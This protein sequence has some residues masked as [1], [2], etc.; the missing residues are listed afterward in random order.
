M[1]FT[2][3]H[4]TERVWQL[5]ETICQIPH[6]SGF[7]KQ[8]GDW[9][10]RQAKANGLKVRRDEVG[11]IRIDRPASPGFGNAPLTILQA[12]LDMVPQSEE[13]E[14]FNFLTG[15]IELKEENGWVRAAKRTT[16]GSD[17][18]IGIAAA[19]ALLFDK[20]FRCGPLAAVFTVEEETGLTGAGALSAAFLKGDFLLNLDSEEEGIFYVGC[21]GGAR[22]ELKFDPGSAEPPAHS[23]GVKITLSGLSGGHSGCNIADRRGNALAYL[24]RFLAEQPGL[25][26]A[27]VSG[28]DLDNVIPRE[29]AVSAVC[30]DTEALKAAALRFQEQL[31]QEFDAPPAFEITVTPCETPLS[32]W[33]TEKQQTILNCL[34]SL[35]NGVIAFDETFNAVRTSSNL[36]AWS[37]RYGFLHVRSSQRSFANA[38]REQLTAE[39]IARCRAAGGECAVGSIYSGWTP[40]RNSVIAELSKTV[41]QETFGKSPE[42]KVI[43]A[44]LECGI[45]QERA[46]SLDMISFG[47]TLTDPHS[48]AEKLEIASVTRFYTFLQA[49]LLKIAKN[50]KD[51]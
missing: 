22:L 5:F 21:A 31:K 8:L 34:S 1:N 47:P 3:P 32:V 49:L 45:I 13:G 28:G 6:P 35:P 16:L 20:E 9:I 24:C 48:P 50:H 4:E 11:N 25:H 15:S 10:I 19:L 7:E 37:M 29:A 43:H 33:Q 30:Q 38:E 46:G 36:A 14:T 23:E 41:Y 17:D 44:G 26:L 12:H 39:L 40:S 18:G 42:V 51:F 27:D 2:V